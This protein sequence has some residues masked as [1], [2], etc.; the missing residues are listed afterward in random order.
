MKRLLF[1]TL[2]LSLFSYLSKATDY[3]SVASGDANNLN[4]WRT[5]PGNV[6][7]TSFTTGNHQFIIQNGHI[8]TTSAEW[9]LGNAT[10]TLQILTGGTLMGDHLIRFTGTFR[11][12]NG[13]TY[14]H[15]NNG[16][17]STFASGSIF[18]GTESFD[19]ASNFE[20]RNWQSSSAGL[21]SPITWGNLIVNMQVN[22]GGVWNWMIPASLT[23][24]GNLDIRSTYTGTPVVDLWL[25]SAGDRAITVA[26]DFL[27]SGNTTYVT[28]K[29]DGVPTTSGVTTMTVDG[30]ITM[31]GAATL[32]LGR[33]SSSLLFYGDYQLKFRG[34]FSSEAT[35]AI[36]TQ[37]R[38][39]FIVADANGTQVLNS[40][41][42]IACSFMVAATSTLDLAAPL[43]VGK[44]NDSRFDVLGTFNDNGFSVRAYQMTV[45]RGV[46]NSTGPFSIE[47]NCI[48]CSSIGTI[49]FDNLTYCSSSGGKGRINFNN[50]TVTL[51]VTNTS[52]SYLQAGYPMYQSSG[53]DIYFTNSIA[54]VNPANIGS[55]YLINTP[56]SILSLDDNSYI[57]GSAIFY[58]QFGT[59]R[60]GSPDGITATGN[61][62]T[63]NVRVSGA[64]NYNNQSQTNFEYFGT[65]PQVTGD[66]LPLT[67]NRILKINNT[68]GMGTSGVTLTRN[69]TVGSLGTLDLTSGKLTSS[70]AALLNI[71]D[72]GTAINYS[73]NSFVTGPMNKT[74]NENF[75]FPV[76]EG[77]TLHQMEL[78]TRFNETTA[79]V[80]QVQ[81]FKANPKVI[82]P[83]TL[84]APMDHM[85]SLEYWMVTKLVGSATLTKRV[86]LWATT[87][88]D[89]TDLSSLVITH[90]VA[91][92]WLNDGNGQ[93]LGVATGPVR[94]NDVTSYGPFTFASLSALPNNP[95]PINL[96]SFDASKLTNTK[97]LV[98]WELAVYCSKDAV[99]EVQ[100]AGI[101]KRFVT[102]GSVGGSETSRF[103]NYTHNGLKTGINY[104]RMKMIDENGRITYSRTVAI[105]NG[106]N[107]L[108]LT[109]L[110]P[111]VVHTT[112]T[113][114]ITSSARNKID[115]VIA[116]VQGR[117]MKKQNYSINA[118]NTSIEIPVAALAAGTYQ[119]FGMTAEGK[120]NVIRFIK[121]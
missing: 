114:T 30:D 32:N 96:I 33:L 20:I 18:S 104:Y 87:Y 97:A 23:I 31:T 76:G 63:G 116:D 50:T 112:A 82:F 118:G 34:N 121:Q 1:L 48:V 113:L 62:T 74:G 4:N 44:D 84:A 53:G 86:R 5:V 70:L 26:G 100:R 3:Y 107:G 77:A 88:S 27:I 75:I 25:T 102:V 47:Y 111:T 21:P 69:T 79:D 41:A 119:L 19:V 29:G 2:L 36:I 39:N 12:E 54:T 110:T 93:F 28:M 24:N 115:L 38:N 13:G 52:G 67:V 120:T 73:D 61:T 105:L 92:T 98:N 81:Y 83:G 56:T 66:G 10:I 103:Y 99:F 57:S 78:V 40:L 8:M 43:V 45:A 101:D 91:G 71:A 60:I 9:V 106:V 108:L 17:V 51:G 68:A 58:G 80:F 11:I 46:F 49:G 59:L 42:P 94:S 37:G 72:N 95:L 16:S 64:K 6:A 89:A 90:H 109:S 85:S 14:I 22:L 55:Q 7:A 35:N 65:T 117:I 15:N